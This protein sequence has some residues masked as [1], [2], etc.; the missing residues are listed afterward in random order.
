MLRHNCYP[1]TTDA[2]YEQHGSDHA[3]A[4]TRWLQCDQFLSM[5]CGLW[6]WLY[7]V[8]LNTESHQQV[9]GYS[10]HPHSAV[11]T[12]QLPLPLSSSSYERQ[13][14]DAHPHPQQVYGRG[15][16]NPAGSGGRCTVVALPSFGWPSLR[17]SELSG[18]QYWSAPGGRAW[19]GNGTVCKDAVSY[20]H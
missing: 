12:E 4:T 8:L 6:A 14:W 10:L 3:V 15:T 2:V 17:W 19:E 20:G 1:M 7:I 16:H 13:N 18:V 11:A 9:L 5:S